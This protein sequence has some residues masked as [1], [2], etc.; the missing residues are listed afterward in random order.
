MGTGRPWACTVSARDG[1]SC[2]LPDEPPDAWPACPV[3][4]EGAGRPRPLPD[5]SSFPGRMEPY[6][7]VKAP[8]Q[9]A[10]ARRYPPEL[11]SGQFAWSERRLPRAVSAGLSTEEGRRI[12]ELEREN[13][14]L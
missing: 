13:R 4:W 11:R 9:D 5:R 2:G 8:S 10:S 14:E 7:L 12:A 1:A 3:V 6:V